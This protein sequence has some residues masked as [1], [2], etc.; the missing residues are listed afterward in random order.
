MRLF[1]NSR[2]PFLE[3]RRRA[4]II[5]GLLMALG[6]GAMIFN[7]A[8]IGSWLEYG[9][10]F[11]GGTVVQVDFNK[12]V[13]AEQLRAAGKGW[14][15]ASIGDASRSEYVIRLPSF[16][17]NIGQDAATELKNAFD[18]R[19]GAS[20]YQVVRTEA[21]GPKVGSELQ[22]RALIAILISFG[23]TLVY[24]AFRFE[25]RFGVAAIVATL[26]DIIITLGFLALLR[27]EISTATVAAFLTIVGYSLNDTIIVFDRIR[28]EVAKRR[29]GDS[30]EALVDRAI[31]E[32]LPRTTLTSGTTLATLAALYIFGG[33]VI[34][35]FAQ[36][37]ILGIGIGTFSSIFVASPLLYFVEGRWP[38]KTKG[39]KGAA[40]ASRAPSAAV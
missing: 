6:I 24:L 22:T 36:V 10:D 26:H 23:A 21:V 34:R 38:P 40:V 20:S 11:A 12:P 37:L 9:V 2:Y 17:E 33:A 8:T 32:T 16:N 4:Y 39:K 19:F 1:E 5:S 30:F 29:R 18:T 31:N 13:T 35:D 3:W 28:E 14:E 7:V 15:I 27:N 25:W